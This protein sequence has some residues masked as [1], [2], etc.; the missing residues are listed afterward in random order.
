MK[1]AANLEIEHEGLICDETYFIL[2]NHINTQ[3]RTSNIIENICH[4]NESLC[5]IISAG[6]RVHVAAVYVLH[7]LN[8]PNAFDKETRTFFSEY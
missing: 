4:W 6:I 7:T 3:S 8:D 2:T 1:K 5:K